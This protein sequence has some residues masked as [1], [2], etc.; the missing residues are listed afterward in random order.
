VILLFLGEFR[1]RSSLRGIVQ[2]AL[3][4]GVGEFGEKRFHVYSYEYCYII[5]RGMIF[6]AVL[7][8]CPPCH[9]FPGADQHR[10]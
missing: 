5:L 3:L 4:S 1:A 8:T 10:L 7:G 6:L 9:F 2:F